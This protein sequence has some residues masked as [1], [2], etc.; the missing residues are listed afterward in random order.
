VE[1]HQ[2]TTLLT[3]ISSHQSHELHRFHQASSQL[4]TKSHISSYRDTSRATYRS[5]D[6]FE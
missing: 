2:F 5:I 3:A 1:Q 6:I 4:L